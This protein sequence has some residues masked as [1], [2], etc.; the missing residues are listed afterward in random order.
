M[1]K[2][3][4]I[5]A[6]NYLKKL[7]VDLQGGLRTDRGMPIINWLI[8]MNKRSMLGLN[9]RT[10]VQQPTSIVRASAMIDI[11]YLLKG[12]A[13]KGD[14][15][16]MFR[17]SPIAL[18]KS[19]GYF[20]L[21]TGR[22]MKDIILDTTPLLDKQYALIQKAD[23]ITWTKIWNAVKYEIED[24]MPGLKVGSKEFFEAV[25][26]RFSNIIDRTQVVDTVLHR[27]E[28]MRDKDSYVKVI[29]SF[30][31][32]PIK[33]Y[34]IGLAAFEKYENDK[35][36]ENRNELIRSM[37][38]LIA[39]T[40]VVSFTTALYDMAHANDDDDETL[41]DKWLG[42]ILDNV[43]GIVPIVKDINSIIQGY[44]VNRMEYIGITK[45]WRALNR[46]YNYL[47]EIA[48]GKKHKYQF[49][50]I[51]TDFIESISYGTGISVSNVTREIET[52]MRKY[53]KI[54]GKDTITNEI[55]EYLFKK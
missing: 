7:M 4:G 1:N 20:N 28:L 27:S 53:I 21:D 17:Y 35:T 12:I 43:T 39:T 41:L 5:Q 14:M 36:P 13:S 2:K 11:K 29:T 25:N 42:D 24:T 32:E 8:K 55:Y 47:E 6:F 15:D 33:Q 10:V 26:E 37:S 48:L 40:A 46:L 50:Y 9:L 18:W 49:G 19:W 51:L 3:F 38:S 23:D 44:S 45:V 22:T 31:S 30:M 34:N 54:A 52:V 16:E